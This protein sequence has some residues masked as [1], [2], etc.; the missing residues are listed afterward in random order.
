MK[1]PPPPLRT[2]RR[3]DESGEQGAGDPD[4]VEAEHDQALQP[5]AVADVPVR[6]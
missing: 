1:P 4:D 3:S 6:E 2:P 5:D